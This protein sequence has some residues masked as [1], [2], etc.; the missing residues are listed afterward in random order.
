MVLLLFFFFFQAEDGIRD[1][2]VTGV[3]TCALPILDA[4]TKKAYTSNSFA[5]VENLVGGINGN[6][7]GMNEMLVVIDGMVR[8]ANNVLPTEIEQITVLKGVA[9]VALYGS[10]AA[11]GV[12]QITTKRGVAGDPS[13]NIR[14][15]T[16]MAVPKAYPKYLNSAEY[17][18]Y[19]NEARDNDGLTPTFSEADIYRTSTG[20]NPYRYPDLNMYSSDYLKSMYNVSEGIEEII[21][22]N[23]RAKY[24]TTTGYMHEGSLMK[25]GNA[26]DNYVSRLFASGNIDM[27]LHE[28][29]NVQTDAN[30]TFY[31]ASSA[32][33]NWWGSA[34][35]LRPNRV[36]PLIPLSYLAEEIGRAS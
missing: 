28:N 26:A 35:T 30:V 12:V 1:A 20:Y 36:A 19:Y 15:N 6:I 13:I 9:A 4:M 14:V 7:W 8:D 16:G 34:A 5:F 33:T 10:R 32:R 2:D 17:M 24:N 27:Q 31:D 23:E 3:Q 22:G 11:K 18:T 25:V 21:S 29:L